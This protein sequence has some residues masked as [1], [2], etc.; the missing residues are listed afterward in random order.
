ME[1]ARGLHEKLFAWMTLAHRSN[2]VATHVAG[3]ER[4]RRPDTGVP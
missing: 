2:L 4:Y 3:I 1:L